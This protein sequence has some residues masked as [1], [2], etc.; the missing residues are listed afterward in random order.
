MWASISG[1][2]KSSRQW[3]FGNVQSTMPSPHFEIAFQSLSIE[4][5]GI[6]DLSRMPLVFMLNS[7]I[8]FQ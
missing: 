5:Y 3:V 1:D 7:Q 8:G 6:I 4:D 2:L